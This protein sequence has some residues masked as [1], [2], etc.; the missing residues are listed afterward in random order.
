MEGQKRAL[1]LEVMT[2]NHPVRAGIRA[3]KIE[4]LESAIQTGKRDGMVPLDV[5]L[6]QLVAA[7]QIIPETARRYAKDPQGL[8]LS[9]PPR[10]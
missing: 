2:V 5:S 4:S 9:P 1:A 10:R 3:G 8:Q 7:G 6:E